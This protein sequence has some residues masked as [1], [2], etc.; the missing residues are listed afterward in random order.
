MAVIQ[1]HRWA[2]WVLCLA[3]FWAGGARSAALENITID[4]N[5]MRFS[6]L[7]AGPSQGPLVL[8]LHG[9]PETSYAWRHQLKALGEMGYRAVAPDQRGYSPGARPTAVA[10]YRMELLVSDVFAIATELGHQRFALV[11]HDWGGAVAWVAASVGAHRIRSLTILSTPHYETLAPRRV[12]GNGSP[13]AKPAYFDQYARAGAEQSLLADGAAELKRIYAGHASDARDLYLRQFRDPAAMRAALNWYR[14]AFGSGDTDNKPFGPVSNRA[15]IQINVPTLYL[16]GAQDPAFARSAAEATKAY[17]GADY[18]FV[19]L[20][21][22]H[23]L[24]EQASEAVNAQLANHLIA[25]TENSGF[26]TVSFP[27][28]DGLEVSADFYP[29]AYPAAPLVLLFHQSGSSRGEFRKVAWRMQELGYNALAVDLRWGKNASGIV[30]ETARRNGTPALIEQVEAGVA[31]PWPTIYASYPDMLAALDWADQQGLRGPRFALGSSFSAMLVLKLGA[32]RPLS[33]VLAYSP[34]EYDEA[35]PRQARAWAQQIKV[36]VLNVA[37]PTEEE[38]VSPIADAVKVRGSQFVIARSGRHGAA[39]IFASEEN[40]QTLAGFLGHHAGGPPRREL[41]LIDLPNRQWLYA[42]RYSSSGE[43]GVALLFHQGGG[44]ARGEY[45]FVIA[46]LLNLGF[47]VIAADLHGGGDRFGPVNRTEA[48]FPAPEDFRYCA[49]GDEVT[50]VVAAARQW[51]PQSPLTLWGSSYSATLAV[52]AGIGGAPAIDR[53]LAFSPAS[54]PLLSECSV[55]GLNKRLPLPVLVVR[56]QSEME[57]PEIARQTSALAAVGAQTFVA[58]PG[59]HGSST[60][61]AVRLG[62][63]VEV[64]WGGIEAFVLG[65]QEIAER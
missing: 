19:E 9:F 2:A 52:Q 45:G 59:L 27:S 8:L 42:D 50:A 65:Q 53:V 4:A 55:D 37:G 16:W 61:N 20:A 49:A 38:L 60:L 12:N 1:T 32:E 41:Q 43:R 15:P 30:N 23:W 47:D 48:R 58:S 14:A 54:G 46:R 7:A 25:A 57:M 63:E 17:V 18:R 34:G 31:S 3:L 36:P 10:D 40:W 29:G 5:G 22:G 26:K 21:A 6:A 28:A 64:A 11:G 44:S 35:A 51:R 39:I 56:P 62:G 33:G 24:T 13:A